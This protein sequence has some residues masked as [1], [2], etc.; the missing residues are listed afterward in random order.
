M[1][2]RHRL[3]Q[4]GKRMFRRDAEEA[5]GAVRRLGEEPPEIGRVIGDAQR[6]IARIFS[7]KERRERRGVIFGHQAG[8]T[9]PGRGGFGKARSGDDPIS[10]TLAHESA[11]ALAGLLG[12]GSGNK[13]GR[14]GRATPTLRPGSLSSKRI[15]PPWRCATAAASDRP[16]PEP[17]RERAPSRRTKRSSTRSRSAASMPGP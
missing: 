10:E 16:R 4:R 15:A 5:R 6:E 11:S 9:P 14:A 7:F 17:G 3:D 13:T 12:E 8:E 2:R 1:A